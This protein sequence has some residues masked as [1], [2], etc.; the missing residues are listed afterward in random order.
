[1]KRL[2]AQID[3]LAAEELKRAS[4]KHPPE[5]LSLHDATGVIYEELQEAVES[6]EKCNIHYKNLWGSTR[7]DN[8]NIP[9]IVS[10]LGHARLAASE[11]VQ[12]CAMCQK[13]M[14]TFWKENM[15][16]K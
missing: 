9:A 15:D 7:K 14:D 6:I 3:V 13:Y 2:K 12:L 10:L 11:C 1:M 16:E 4:E 8:I 5:F